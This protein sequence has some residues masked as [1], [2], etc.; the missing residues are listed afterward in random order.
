MAFYLGDTKLTGTGVQVDDSLSST[1]TNPVENKA[2]TEALTDVG[3]SEWQKPSDWIDIRSGALPNSVYFLV[4]HSSDYTTYPEFVVRATVS[5]SGTYDVYVD[6]IKRATTASGTAT[7]LNWQTLALAS[8]FDTIYPSSLRTH[9]VRVTP[10][11]DTNAIT[12]VRATPDSFTAVQGLLWVHFTLDNNISLENFGGIP[13]T[14]SVNTI[15]QAITSS[16]G[17]IKATSLSRAF[18]R[19]TALKNLPILKGQSNPTV[20]AAVIEYDDNLEVVT[21]SGGKYNTASGFQSVPKLKKIYAT[22]GAVFYG[23][24]MFHNAP[25]L[26]NLVTC[27]WNILDTFA[28]MFSGDNNLLP[29]TVDLSSNTTLKRFHSG[30]TFSLKGVTVSNQAPFTGTSPQIDIRYTGLDRS[31]LVNL[32]NSMPTVTGSQVCNVTGCTGAAELTASD[33]AIATEKGWTITR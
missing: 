15:C 33:I 30:G 20:A 24:E 29:F 32:F 22:D 8:G 21:F 3:Y 1:S 27:D 26:Q 11:V 14:N 12:A 19:M 13:G 18:Y 16:T 2:V 17:Y 23:N 10:S 4:A 31:A 25:N 9:I 28:Y 7:T 5:N 6:G